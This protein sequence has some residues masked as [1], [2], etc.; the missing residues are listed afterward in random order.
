MSLKIGG[1]VV[2]GPAEEILVL[3]RPLT[4]DIVIRAQAV[5]DYSLFDALCP[6]PKP[7]AILRR[8]Q[9]KHEGNFEDPSYLR[10]LE[11]HSQI[12][13][14]FICIQ[15]LKPSNIEWSEV[16]EDKPHTWMKWIEELRS[17]GISDL[18]TQRIMACVMQANSLDDNKLKEARELFLH[19]I[20]QEANESSGPQTELPTS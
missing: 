18:E 11:K 9:V 17:A 13:F 20:R 7:P 4:G 3:P 14:A 19:G 15:S 1:V 10:L 16:V 12:R 2:Q 6:P 8:G 5:L